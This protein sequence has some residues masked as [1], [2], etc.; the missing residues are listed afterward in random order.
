MIG[1]NI[2]HYQITYKTRSPLMKTNLML[3]LMAL[4]TIGLTSC[5]DGPRLDAQIVFESER[6]APAPA[7]RFGGHGR[8]EIY[9]WMRMVPISDD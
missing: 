5:G 3:L 2:S 1:Q 7:I 8:T 4:L 6:D 9:V